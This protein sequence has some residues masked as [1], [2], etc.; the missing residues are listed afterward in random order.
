MTLADIPPHTRVFIDANT[1]I[2]HFAPHPVLQVPCRQFLERVY[3]NIETKD[4]LARCLHTKQ[5]RLT[6]GAKTTHRPVITAVLV[7]VLSLLLK[8]L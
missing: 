6:S 5:H 8:C 4:H 1:L 2:Y 7:T 3:Q